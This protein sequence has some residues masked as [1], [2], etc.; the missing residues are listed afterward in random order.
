MGSRCGQVVD[1]ATLPRG[2]RR[3]RFGP[4]T[5]Q[6]PTIPTAATANQPDPLLLHHLAPPLHR[7]NFAGL[8]L[9]RGEKDA[10]E[11]NE[12]ARPGS[13]PT[14]KSQ[15]WPTTEHDPPQFGFVFAQLRPA[16]CAQEKDRRSAGGGPTV[17]RG[18]SQLGL[19]SAGGCLGPQGRGVDVRL[20]STRSVARTRTFIPCTLPGR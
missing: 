13:T 5:G 2:E 16:A 10:T 1:L 12:Y 7:A 18:T 17:Y 19:A 6:F 8:H 3:T 11:C 15:G 14:G 20:N 9:Y 4:K